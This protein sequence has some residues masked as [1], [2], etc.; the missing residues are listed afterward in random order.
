MNADE[1]RYRRDRLCHHANHPAAPKFLSA[2]I[3]V[4]PRQK[5]PSLL[6]PSA[7]TRQAPPS[8]G[9]APH[10]TRPRPPP[11]PCKSPR[12]NPY[13]QSANQSSRRRPRSPPDPASS[14]PDPPTAGRL[15]PARSPNSAAKCIPRHNPH[16]QSA[17]QSRRRRPRSP[18]DPL[19]A[20]SAAAG[21]LR[22]A[23][24]HPGGK[25]HPPATTHAQ[26]ANQSSRRRPRSPPDPAS[27][28]PDPP[29]AGRLRPARSHP[30][31]KMHPPATTRTPRAPINRD[32]GARIL[33][34]TQH[35]PSRIRRLPARPTPHPHG[36]T[37]KRT[38][39]AATRTPRETASPLRALRALRTAP[40]CA[41]HPPPRPRH[42]PPPPLLLRTIPPCA[43]PRTGP[44][45]P[46]SLP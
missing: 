44:Y 37:A 13:A 3:R 24:S 28:K 18:P 31:G 5:Y 17:N 9:A 21:R 32:A 45:A 30:G 46:S 27:S 20:G 29:P 34:P 33:L 11:R 26:S 12:H 10:A 4:H 16:T 39:P 25:M 38:P 36:P 40:C 35:P 22:P 1:R 14:K 15:R 41:T 42:T 23:R 7:S 6:F 8:T 19:Q 2:F 43:S